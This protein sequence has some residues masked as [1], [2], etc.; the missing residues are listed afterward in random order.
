MDT[1]TAPSYGGYRF[2]REIIAHC[3]W[4]YYRFSLSLRDIQELMLERGVV[5]SHETIRRW[6]LKFGADYARRLQRSRGRMG[7]TWY[8]DEVFCRINGQLVYLWRAVDHDGETLDI[9]VQSRRNAKAAKRF[10][11]KLLKGLRY[12][13]RVLVTD[14]LSSYTVAHEE[15]MPGV[16][17]RRG[18]RVNNRAENSHQPTRE[19]ERRMRSFKSMKHAQRFLSTH[20]QVSNHFRCA[21]HLMRACHYRG[22][23]IK[24]FATWRVICGL[25]GASGNDGHALRY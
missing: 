22:Q 15:M 19:R 16:N 23:M 10:F 6:C 7:D 24:Q 3:A 18:G 1:L 14:K 21:R 20:G 4:L 13:P 8:L 11:R 17:H 2:P 9:L 25:R 5:V 12:C